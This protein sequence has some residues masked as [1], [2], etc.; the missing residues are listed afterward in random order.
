[1][2]QGKFVFS[3]L[4][5][6]LPQRV[7]D[8][9]VEKYQ[10]NKYV[11][12]FSCWNQLLCMLFGQLSARD[13]LRDLLISI[14]AHSG[15]FYHLGFGKNVTRSNLAKANENRN[16]KIFE[17]F[18]Y[19]LIDKAR[20]E[21]Q[22]I[23]DNNFNLKGNIYAIDS[24]TIDLC[25]N[26]FWWA[27]FRKTKGGIK[28]HTMYDIKTSIPSFFH[29][30]TAS[31]H[32]VN[33]LD[34]IPYEAGSYYIVDRGYVDFKR[35]YHIHEKKSFFVTR[36][37]SNFRFQRMYSREVN[38]TFGVM[39]DQIGKLEGYYA[40]KDYPDRLR[41]I[42]YFDEETKRNFIFITNNFDLKSEEIAQL[43]KHR[44]KVELFFKWIKQH[45]KLKTF[46]GTTLNAVKIQIYCA[47]ITYCLI[48]IISRALSINKSIYEILQI[49]NIS[50]LDK[51]PVK[52]LLKNQD[53]KDVKEL[54]YIQLKISGF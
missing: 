14:E 39:C 10:G 15:K 17:E 8:G 53:Y 21:C 16:C 44:W 50:L 18:A 7:F 4:V 48:A 28:M 36:A 41:R 45:L 19:H 30:T 47:I 22:P 9:I 29:I 5:E 23:D 2:N 25:L 38:K 26:V 42:K 46:W 40:I 54:S 33:V 32:D 34:I 49:L 27:E 24:T 11:K 6:F 37:K 35:L 3:Q 51:T 31:I 43:Y 20:K 12:H 13:S 52:E 1:M